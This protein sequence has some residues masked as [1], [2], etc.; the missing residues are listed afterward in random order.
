V[1]NNQLRCSRGGKISF[2]HLIG[3]A[4]VR[5]LVDSPV[6]NSILTKAFA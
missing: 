1:I 6:M 2:T 4:V 5:A 3:F